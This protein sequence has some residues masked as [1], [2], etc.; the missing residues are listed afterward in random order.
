VP[1]LVATITPKPGQLDA[2]ESALKSLIP[3]I[4]E[5]DGCELYA[6]HR[7]Q[8]RLVFVEKWRDMAALGAHGSSDNIKALN[9][10]LRGLVDGPPDIQVLEAVPAG[11]AGKGAV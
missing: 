3:A 5:E 11:D 2:A 1:V 8:D 9:Q 6:L 4:H 7:G 10:K